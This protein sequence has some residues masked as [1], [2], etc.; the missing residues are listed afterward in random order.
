MTLK[1][2]IEF[3]MSSSMVQCLRKCWSTCRY[4]SL[5]HSPN[6][7]LSHMSTGQLMY[8]SNL[9][10]IF[11]FPFSVSLQNNSNSNSDVCAVSGAMW[12]TFEWTLYGNLQSYY[13]FWSKIW[14]TVY[15]L[16]DLICILRYMREAFVDVWRWGARG[17][18]GE[19]MLW[20]SNGFSYS[21]HTRVHTYAHTT[22]IENVF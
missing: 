16:M 17:R 14:T 20:P 8:D 4:H 2:Q 1:F 10:S 19:G 7:S 6:P 12:R 3:R 13:T 22:H 9:N 15:M 11:H 21:L 18:D 5:Y